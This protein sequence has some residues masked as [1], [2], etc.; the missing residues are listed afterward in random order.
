MMPKPRGSIADR[1]E[2]HVLSFPEDADIERAVL[3]VFR[4]ICA[5]AKLMNREIPMIRVVEL[6]EREMYDEAM[7]LVMN[8]MAEHGAVAAWVH[9]SAKAV[10]GF[11]VTTANGT[12]KETK[13]AV[14]IVERLLN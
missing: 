5:R 12:V 11:R 7:S 8:D 10:V 3:Q 9:D 1:D 13:H 4:Q 2:F 6:T 14:R